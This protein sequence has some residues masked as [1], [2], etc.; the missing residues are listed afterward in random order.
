MEVRVDVTR[1]RAAVSAPSAVG[2][3]LT[4]PGSAVDDLEGRFAEQGGEE[5]AVDRLLRSARSKLRR[6]D[7]RQVPAAIAAGAVLV[8]IRP[9]SQRV[10]DGPVQGAVVI[11][12]NVLEWRCDPSSP[13]RDERVS[14]PR[15]R[16]ILL[17]DEGCQSSL[18]A[19]A[20]HDLGHPDATDVVGGVQAWRAAEM[21]LV[22]VAA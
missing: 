22:A 13:A 5:A 3:A 7:P 16:L 12:R 21:P 1:V 6:L 4:M 14:D 9:D 10:R 19:A 20:L 2:I 11:C 18:A 8:D 15:R 17:C